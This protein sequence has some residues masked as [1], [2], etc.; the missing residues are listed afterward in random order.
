MND[1]SLYLFHLPL[2]LHLLLFPLISFLLLSIFL[3]SPPPC[4]CLY[5]FSL[6]HPYISLIVSPFTSSCSSTV[7]SFSL[8]LFSSPLLLTHLSLLFSSSISSSSLLLRC[9]VS[10][11]SL[12]LSLPV[13]L[14]WIFSSTSL[15]PSSFS[16]LFNT[17]LFH[18]PY[19]TPFLCFSSPF[20]FHFS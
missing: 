10:L 18:S 2:S 7:L 6:F 16:H 8:T 14:F 20:S 4:I 9:L 3:S 13:P 15:H 12:H 17:P 11:P 19:P 1:L 5:L